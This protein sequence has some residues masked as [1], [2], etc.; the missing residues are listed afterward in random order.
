M[1][2]GEVPELEES[3][4]RDLLRLTGQHFPMI[5][6]EETELP[7][8]SGQS[9][10]RW[11]L[12]GQEIIFGLP[13]FQQRDQWRLLGS[14]VAGRIA[15]IATAA[16]QYSE[17]MPD[18]KWVIFIQQQTATSWQ[19][20]KGDDVLPASLDAVLDTLLLSPAEQVDLVAL[21]SLLRELSHKN[22]TAL[23]ASGAGSASASISDAS[24]PFAFAA[25]SG[26]GLPGSTHSRTSA[27][28]R[29]ASPANITAALHDL[30]ASKLAPLWR[31]ITRPSATAPR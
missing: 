14:Y 25:Q 31:R 26:L 21:H 28:H 30:V 16:A 22:K 12:P 8:L 5:R 6:H 9:I 18:L 24:A 4:F 13:P 19:A 3:G 23:T 11:Q 15:E 27:H 10:P 20:L 29:P 1:H 7:G 17:P 2:K